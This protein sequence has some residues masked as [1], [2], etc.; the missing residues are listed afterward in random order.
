MTK[1]VEAYQPSFAGRIDQYVRPRERRNRERS[2]RQKA[3]L[4]LSVVLVRR[5][6]RSRQQALLPLSVARL[7]ARFA[8]A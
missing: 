7:G 3:M 1:P 6:L 2:E 4:P 5:A 8:R